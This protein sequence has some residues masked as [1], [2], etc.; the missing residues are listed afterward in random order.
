M[1]V[2][3]LLACLC[4]GRQVGNPSVPLFGKEGLGEILRI[5]LFKKS[6][7]IPLCAKGGYKNAFLGEGTLGHLYVYF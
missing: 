6:P 2:S 1:I 5:D 7:S 3:F 4:V